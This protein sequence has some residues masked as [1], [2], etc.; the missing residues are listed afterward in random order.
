MHQV[1]TFQLLGEDRCFGSVWALMEGS[2]FALLLNTFSSAFTKWSTCFLRRYCLVAIGKILAQETWMTNWHRN[3]ANADKFLG[4]ER[5]TAVW[6]FGNPGFAVWDGQSVAKVVNSGDI[7]QK[8]RQI[9][10]NEHSATVVQQSKNAEARRPQNGIINRNSQSTPKDSTLIEWDLNGSVS[11][12]NWQGVF[13]QRADLIKKLA[14]P[15]LHI[16][17][18]VP[19]KDLYRVYRARAVRI[20]SSRFHPFASAQI[21]LKLDVAT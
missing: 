8:D 17:W 10:C 3:C 2:K 5:F 9:P 16:L 19:S 18:S 4:S 11:L 20:F 13:L 12:R 1:S 6:T 15:K 14:I 7:F 21:C